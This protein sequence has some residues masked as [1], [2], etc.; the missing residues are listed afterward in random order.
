M[1]GDVPT[2]ALGLRQDDDMTTPRP[3]I[4]VVGT[5]GTIAGSS[6]AAD[7][8][9]YEAGVFSVDDL[10]AAVPGLEA[11]ADIVTTT[12]SSVDSVEMDLGR[13]VALARA[14]AEILTGSDPAADD[15]GRRR[16]SALASLG[17]VDGVVVTHG[18]DT[19]EE[20]AYLLH[21]VLDTDIPVVLTGAM[22]PADDPGADGPANLLDAV[23]VAADP[24]A[25]G[26][27][28]LVVFGGLVH[29]ARDVVK[30][31][32][33]TLD[34]F[35]SLHGPLG[36]IVA[37]RVHVHAA[38]R[39]VRG[40]FPVA[41][42]PGT[43]PRVE[44]LATHPEQSSLIGRAVVESRPAGLV[45]VGS[46]GGNVC[47]AG[48]TALDEARAAGLAVVRASRTGAGV[49][50]RGDAIDDDA[51]DWVAA[52]DLPPGKA[53]VLLAL[54]LTRTTD[55]AELQRVFDTH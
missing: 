55:T 18:T 20:S 41:D 54:A 22:R 30:R 25:R 26:L 40:T 48:I 35:S 51:H 33:S 3:R 46:G 16:R 24:A 53:R 10:T 47:A 43:L 50:G 21:L 52:G 8:H 27:G 7:G 9:H 39:R 32:A 15:E 5:G 34:A 6:A 44:M 42:L 38:S 14:L 31:A 36:E 29:G 11:V 1:F 4:A 12:V 23:R 19:M 2:G 17:R 49:V 37:G 45:H 28:V 13:R